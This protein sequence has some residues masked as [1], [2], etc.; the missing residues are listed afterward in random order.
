LERDE[1][2]G[3]GFGLGGCDFDEPIFEQE[4]SF[5]KPVALGRAQASKVS[6]SQ[7]TPNVGIQTECSRQHF[8]NFGWGVDFDFPF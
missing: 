2:S 6:H 8:G 7:V 3:A 4:G 5:G 1:S